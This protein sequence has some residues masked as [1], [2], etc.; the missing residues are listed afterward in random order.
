[1]LSADASGKVT[2]VNG[3]LLLVRSSAWVN[4]HGEELGETTIR[5]ISKRR[6]GGATEKDKWRNI[7]I[8]LIDPDDAN[9]RTAGFL[10]RREFFRELTRRK[11]GIRTL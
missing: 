7:A 4:P 10:C 5:T 8:T 3:W 9:C 6:I 2:E 1:L 11:A